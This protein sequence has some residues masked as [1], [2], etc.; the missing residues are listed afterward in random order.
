MH[1]ANPH[2]ASRSW[3]AA[4]YVFLVYVFVTGG[5]SQ[6]R[7]WTDAIAQ[8]TALPILAVGTWRLSALP[9]S[10]V[11]SLGLVALTAI[12]LLPWLQLL[13]LTEG[14]WNLAPARIWR[15]RAYRMSLPPGR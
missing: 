10:P 8:V 14:L 1:P 13:P 12:V 2:A 7:G 4:L 3:H 15:P 9:A 11:R 5:S 6:A